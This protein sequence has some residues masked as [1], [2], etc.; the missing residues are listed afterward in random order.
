[1]SSNTEIIK[2]RATAFRLVYVQLIVAVVVV[3]LSHVYSGL[4]MSYSASLGS[5]A[6]IL[7]NIYFVR[8]VFRKAES[9]SPQSMVNWLYLG[10]A[11]KIFLTIGLFA[12]CF[13]LV[14]PLHVPAVFAAYVVV[15]VVNLVGMALVKGDFEKNTE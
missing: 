6:Y 15:M 8:C 12:M 3:L 10:E 2:N 1:M 5:A 4:V 13:A 11:L 9:Q 7:P 14:K